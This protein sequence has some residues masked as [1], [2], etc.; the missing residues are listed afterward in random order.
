M[1][2]NGPVGLVTVSAQWMTLSSPAGNIHEGI[3][4]MATPPEGVTIAIPVLTRS[5]LANLSRA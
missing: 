3:Q 1:V 5:V 2:G 4:Q